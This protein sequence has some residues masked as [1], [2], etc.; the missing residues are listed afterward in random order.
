MN[1]ARKTPIAF[2]LASA[3]ACGGCANQTLKHDED[4]LA[5]YISGVQQQAASFAASRDLVAKA[6]E[7]DIDQIQRDTRFQRERAARTV[8]GWTIA[9]DPRLTLFNGVR[10]A[11]DAGLQRR[12]DAEAQDAA[13]KR[14]VAEATGKIAIHEDRLAAA[15][16]GLAQLSEGETPIHR[17]QAFVAFAKD[18]RDRTE[19]LRQEAE[20][21]A[22][23][24]KEK[25]ASAS[26]PAP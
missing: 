6:R 11:A 1:I 26:T 22:K 17:F 20:N 13:G 23:Q 14:A 5:L 7:A 12:L 16:K 9:N 25:S 4:R 19:K 8:D 2:L 21:E 10:T 15:A 3:V 18:V 24:A